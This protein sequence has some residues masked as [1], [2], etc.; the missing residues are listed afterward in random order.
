[1]F[2]RV[3][4]FQGPGAGFRSSLIKLHF[5]KIKVHI[6]VY[7][8]SNILVCVIYF[9]CLFNRDLSHGC[10]VYMFSLRFS[11]SKFLINRRQFRA[12]KIFSCA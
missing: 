10:L 11:G 2:S 9:V 1:M 5:K 7:K 4:L 8:E 3:Q 12:R 6:Q